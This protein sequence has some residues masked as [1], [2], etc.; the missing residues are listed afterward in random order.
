M[1]R[2]EFTKL[3]AAATPIAAGRAGQGTTEKTPYETFLRESSVS[4]EVIDRWLRGPSWAR[5][6]PELG[7]VLWNYMPLDG[8]DGSATISA[9]QANGARTSFMYP[10]R[11]CR[12]N[13]GRNC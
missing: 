2:R 10:D 12:I 6:D 5:F 13:T 11:K 7:Y 4:R 8:I 3:A 9:I 1:K